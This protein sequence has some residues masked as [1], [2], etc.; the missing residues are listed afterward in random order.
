MICVLFI[1]SMRS[2]RHHHSSR[3]P[4]NVCR[5]QTAVDRSGSEE[6]QRCSFLR[7]MPVFRQRNISETI[8]CQICLLLRLGRGLRFSSFDCQNTSTHKTHGYHLSF[9]HLFFFLFIFLLHRFSISFRFNLPFT[10]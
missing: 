6:Q 4:Q 1:H 9:Q 2:S 5:C 8:V 7:I 10:S 3:R